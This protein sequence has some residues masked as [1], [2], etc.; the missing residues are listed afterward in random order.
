MLSQ[1]SSVVASFLRLMEFADSFVAFRALDE[2]F[3]SDVVRVG[4]FAINRV[5]GISRLHGLGT[6]SVCE[7]TI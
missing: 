3:M 7:T 5:H 2:V 1:C 4:V 6:R